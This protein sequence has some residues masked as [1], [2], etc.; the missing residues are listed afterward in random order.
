MA[1]LPPQGLSRHCPAEHLRAEAERDRF[2]SLSR[3]LLCVADFQGYFQRLNPAWE[4]TLGYALAE[5]LARP[6]LDFVHP[7]DRA[8]T[9]AEA[10][11]L[12][13][14]PEVLD[15]NAIVA[16]VG[17]MQ[18]RFIGD[19][20]KLVTVAAP[21]LSKVKADPGQ[22][23]QVIVNLAV[24]A[25]DAATRIQQ[26]HPEACVLY[27]SG[28]TDDAIVHHGVL[29]EGLSLLSK[30]F[31]AETLLRKVPEVLDSGAP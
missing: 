29:E 3:D 23:E 11:K 24:N 28:S 26:S 5:L 14:A 12:V 16:D 18:H 6:C 25:R 30:P 13:L 4:K 19:D 21:D 15:L 7:D 8:A 31:T 2:F 22:M 10:A 20:I 17:R 1:A 27:T 9:M